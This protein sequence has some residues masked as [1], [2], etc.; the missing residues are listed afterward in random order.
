MFTAPTA[1]DLALYLG[2]NEI[3]GN[4]ADLLIAQAVALAT[5][6]VSPLPNGATAVVLSAAGRAYSNPS[7][8]TYETIGP[9]SV[10]RP[11]AG[12]Y[13][14]RAEKSALKAMAGRGGAF[15]VDPT[16]ETAT[17]APTRPPYRPSAGWSPDP[18]LGHVV[19][20]F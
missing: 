9:M 6:V 10:Q 2:L 14:T 12:L 7:G 17:P 8:A 20:W 16:P 3:Q 1:E 13:L 18:S 5:A 11:Q 15:T 19:G 4:R